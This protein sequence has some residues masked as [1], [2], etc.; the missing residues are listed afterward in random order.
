MATPHLVQI[1]KLLALILRHRPG[2]FGIVLDAEGY[3]GLD[4]VLAAVRTRIAGATRADLEA[5][6]SQVEPEKTRYRIEDGDIRANY[7]H[8]LP[9]RIEQ[10]RAD[11]PPVL[12][13]G[14]PEQALGE[15]GRHGLLPMRR[16]YVHLTTGP[17]LAVRIGARHG[18][19]RLLKVDAARAHADGVDFYRA[20]DAFWLAERIPPAYLDTLDT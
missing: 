1:S 9:E 8:S 17:E 10:Q 14:T 5:V 18:R 16:Q 2:E 11:P 13:H 12:W 3:A 15:I 6:V 20:N 7:G 4:E 19:P